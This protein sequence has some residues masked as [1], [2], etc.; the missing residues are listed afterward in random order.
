M[1]ALTLHTLKIE[2]SRDSFYLDSPRI[3]AWLER[4][5]RSPSESLWS[6]CW[7]ERDGKGLRFRLGPV[8]GSVDAK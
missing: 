2:A 1:L 3:G 4:T 8:G 7:I 5:P 6:T